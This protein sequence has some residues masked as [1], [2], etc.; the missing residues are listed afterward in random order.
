LKEGIKEE[1]KKGRKGWM[2]GNQRGTC[3]ENQKFLR[4]LISV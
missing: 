1:N 2:K 4:F 3:F